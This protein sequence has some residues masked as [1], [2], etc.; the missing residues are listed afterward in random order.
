MRAE[1]REP[2]DDDRRG[3]DLAGGAHLPEPSPGPPAERSDRA[4]LRRDEDARP[5]DRRTGGKRSADASGP[6]DLPGRGVDRERRARESVDVEL[7]LAVDGR[8]LDVAAEPA[9]PRELPRRQ[10]ERRIGAG[11]GAPGVGA[12]GAP[13]FAVADRLRRRLGLRLGRGLGRDGDALEVGVERAR[14]RLLPR[15]GDGDREPE[16]REHEHGDRSEDPG[17]GFRHEAAA[18]RVGRGSVCQQLRSG[19]RGV[20]R[21]LRR[22]AP[23]R[24]PSARAAAVS[25]MTPQVSGSSKK[26]A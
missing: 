23:L 25:P 4:V 7:T 17:E 13:A 24:E 5:V 9:R 21:R 6:P 18:G 3:L 14:G 20:G 11:E 15:Q 12:E 26:P 22:G 1:V 2:V 8:E 16:Q 19:R 10:P